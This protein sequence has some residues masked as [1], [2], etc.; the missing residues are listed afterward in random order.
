MTHAIYTNGVDDTTANV[1]TRNNRQPRHELDFS[2]CGYWLDSNKSVYRHEMT[3]FGTDLPFSEYD[4]ILQACQR[5]DVKM[6]PYSC[7][8][9][10][11][12]QT[13]VTGWVDTLGSRIELDIFHRDDLTFSDNYYRLTVITY[14]QR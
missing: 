11:G 14:T 10:N 1:S 2:S 8:W 4:D 6:N 12:Q 3:S 13:R 5:H 7:L 9:Y